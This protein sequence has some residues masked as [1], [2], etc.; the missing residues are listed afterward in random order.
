ME[1]ITG[2]IGVV[3]GKF[4]SQGMWSKLGLSWDWIETSENASMWTGLQDYSELERERFQFWLDRVYEDFT[5]KV[6]EGRGMPL[7]EVQKIAKGR[8]WTGVQAKE[9]GLIDEVGGYDVALRL[10]REAAGLDPDAEIRLRQYPRPK[11]P[12]QAFLDEGPSSSESTAV[13]IRALEQVQPAMRLAQR[14]GLVEPAPQTLA[15][16]PELEPRP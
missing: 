3:G 11:K 13:L 2:S 1:T 4:L 16:P 14:L 6:A 9:I 10:A 15:M 7:E 5:T 12:W 8:V